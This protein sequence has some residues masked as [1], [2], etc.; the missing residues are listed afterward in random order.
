[1]GRHTGT[2]SGATQGIHLTVGREGEV[3][4]LQLIIGGR[5]GNIREGEDASTAISNHQNCSGE[6]LIN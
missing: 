5:V 4:T 1:M 6:I 2:V 3:E